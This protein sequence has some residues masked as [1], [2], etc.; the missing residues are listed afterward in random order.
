MLG[1]ISYPY[2]YFNGGLTEVPLRVGHSWVITYSN[3]N[4]NNIESVCIKRSSVI[5]KQPLPSWQDSWGQH[6]AQLGPIGPMWAP[7]WP[8]EPHYLGRF[9]IDA[10]P[11]NYGNLPDILYIKLCLSLSGFIVF[12]L[13]VN[14]RTNIYVFNHPFLSPPSVGHPASP[15][16][17]AC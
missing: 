7:C 10:F 15:F 12:C 4:P 1:S 9:E 5:T 17:T 3:P 2:P 11:R 13:T 16:N 6:G 14:T 8:H